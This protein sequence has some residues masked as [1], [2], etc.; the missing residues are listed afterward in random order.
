[1]EAHT[2]LDRGHISELETGKRAALAG[3]MTAY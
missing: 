3:I 1:M 2:D